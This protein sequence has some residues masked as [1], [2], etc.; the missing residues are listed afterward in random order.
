MTGSFYDDLAPDYHL[1]FADWEASMVRQAEWVHSLV[2]SEWPATRSV[3]DAAAGIGTQALGLAALGYRVTAS[4]ASGRALERAR[5]EADVRGLDVRTVV[6]DLR[7]LSASADEFDLVIACDNALPHLL[8]DDEILRALRECHRSVRPGGG[9]LFSVRDYSAPGAGTE[10][11]PYGVRRTP[12]GRAILFQVWDW[13]GP[14]YDTSL[15]IVHDAET[16]GATTQVFRSRY[17][18]VA[19]SRLLELIAQAGFENVRRIDEGFYQPVLI[20]TKPRVG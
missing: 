1:L 6:A 12:D 19:P 10:F 5:R 8:S 14:H 20:G 17:Y 13:D 9:C 3:L 16:G 2:Q 7:S 15:Y 11:H 18:A 4:D